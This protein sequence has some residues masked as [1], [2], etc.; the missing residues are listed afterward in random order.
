MDLQSIRTP[1][2]LTR[3]QTA[4]AGPWLE[5]AAAASD[6][7]GWQPLIYNKETP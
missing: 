2:T 7:A 3:M 4:G 5:A 1:I 6:N